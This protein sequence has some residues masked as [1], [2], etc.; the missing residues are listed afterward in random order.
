MALPCGAKIESIEGAAS[1]VGSRGE[2]FPAPAGRPVPAAHP[3]SGARDLHGSCRRAL[4]IPPEKAAPA[5][6]LREGRLRI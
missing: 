3:L 1:E 2:Q 4:R 5:E 6:R